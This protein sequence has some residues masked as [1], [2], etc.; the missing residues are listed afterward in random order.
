MA[1]NEE[2]NVIDEKEK[3]AIEW[4]NNALFIMMPAVG[5]IALIFGIIGTA[6][7]L[8]SNDPNFKDAKVGIAVFLIILALLGAGGVA[9]GVIQFLTRRKSKYRKPEKEPDK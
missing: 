2:I 6:F 5:L 8:S 4:E 7:A 3:K 1:K 9:Y